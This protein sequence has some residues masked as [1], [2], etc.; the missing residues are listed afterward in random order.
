MDETSDT[1][2]ISPPKGDKNARISAAVLGALCALVIGAYAWFADPPFS[3]EPKS[4]PAENSYYNLLV[5]GFRAGQLNLNKAAPPELARLANPYNPAANAAY[6][7]NA[8]D[9]SYYRGKLYLYFGVSPALVL[10]WPYTTLTGHYLSDTDAVVIFFAA[11]FLAAAGLLYAIWRRYF[12]EVSIWAPAAGMLMLGLAMLTEKILSLW[13]NVYEVATVAGFAFTML[14]LAGI[15]RALHAPKR[16]VTWLLLASLAYGLAVGSRPSLLFGIIILLAPA[17]R[18]WASH[19]EPGSRR[20]AGCLLAAAAGPAMLVGLGLM[21]YNSL[22]FQNPFEF[23]WHYQLNGDYQPTTARPFSLHYLWFNARFYFFGS[24]AWSARFPFLHAAS[25]PPLPTGYDGAGG[26]YGGILSNYPLVWPVLAVPWVWKNRPAEAAAIL[27]WFVA[28][29][30]L[31]FLLCALTLCLFFTAGGHYESDFLPA[32]LLLAAV[33]ILGCE[34]AL[35]GSPLWRRLARGGWC[36]LFAYSAAFNLFACVE[37]RANAHHL[38]ANS[39]LAHGAVDDAIHQYHEA[40]ALWPDSPNAHAG[41][42]NAL[43]HK[44]DLEAAIAEYQKAVALKPDFAGAFNN[45]G[46]CLLQSGRVDEAI[47]QYRKAV[48]LQPQWAPS[49][50]GLATALFQKGRLD[51]AI[52]QFQA[53]QALQPDS[54]DTCERLGDALFRKGRLPDAIHQYQK[55]LAIDPDFAQAHNN[56]GYCLFQMGRLDEAIAQYQKAVELQPRFAAAYNNLGKAFRQK[57]LPSDALAS[58]Q[59][60]VT[61][62]PQSLPPQINLAWMLATWPD[63]SIRNGPRAV[64]LAQQASQLTQ[65]KDASALRTLAAAY[66][67]TGQFEQAIATEQ[68]AVGLNSSSGDPASAKMDRQLLALFEAHQPYHET[69]VNQ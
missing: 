31:L 38:T 26:P 41:L 29:I 59:K 69:S 58:F 32:L 67:E 62:D 12:P 36:L 43:F 50:S 1:P 51:E 33:G 27:R 5:Q 24:V 56:L 40:L 54:A 60:A 8:Y 6:I 55:A 23:G 42:G 61:L 16:P 46:Y 28:A 65:D 47:A 7:G 3:L 20:R 53:A 66:A 10:F 68:K 21:V 52:V 44:G 25:L 15:W 18:A 49:H 17:G 64:A 14:A 19:R 35:A 37:L 34:R 39:L 45:L 9:M 30:F 4:P 13:C 2:K 63:P 11:G 48:A 22:R 57:N